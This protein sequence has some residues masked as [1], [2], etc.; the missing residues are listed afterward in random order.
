M[1]PQAEHLAA[2]SL[3]THTRGPQDTGSM[4]PLLKAASG[5][6][7]TCSLLVHTLC[8]SDLKSLILPPPSVHKQDVYFL[9]FLKAKREV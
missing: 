5:P 1:I 6:K 7:I 2:M 3:L 4:V 8:L 9:G